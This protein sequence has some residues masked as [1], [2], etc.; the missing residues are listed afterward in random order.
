MSRAGLKTPFTPHKYLFVIW[1]YA[2]SFAGYEQQVNYNSIV[3]VCLCLYLFCACICFVLVFVCACICF[4]LVLVLVLVFV[5]AR[6]LFVGGWY[7]FVIW[8]VHSIYSLEYYL[9]LF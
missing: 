9:N 4:V 3:Y 5:C 7:L 1:K 2:D 6:L 8:C